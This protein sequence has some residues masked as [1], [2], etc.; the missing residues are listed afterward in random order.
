MNFFIKRLASH[1]EETGCVKQHLIVSTTTFYYYTANKI[2]LLNL[3]VC[4]VKKFY[5]G[6]KFVLC[7]YTDIDYFL[8]IS[9]KV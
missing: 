2:F 8:E 5:K 3:L 1:T 6:S 9:Q 7:S 4:E